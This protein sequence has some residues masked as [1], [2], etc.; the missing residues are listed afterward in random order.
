MSGLRKVAATEGISPQYAGWRIVFFCFSIL[1]IAG[2]ALF[3][4]LWA[5]GAFTNTERATHFNVLH[6]TLRALIGTLIVGV[7]L[8][9]FFAA[10]YWTPWMLGVVELVR[11][12]LN[13]GSRL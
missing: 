5:R 11:A 7:F 3:T 10:V 4:Y 8:D 6:A 2:F 9:A 1:G 12:I 13:L